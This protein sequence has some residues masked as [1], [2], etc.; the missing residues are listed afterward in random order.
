MSYVA[1]VIFATSG[2]ILCEYKLT[3][4]VLYQTLSRRLS[5][6]FQDS[7]EDWGNESTRMREVYCRAIFTIAA[8]AAY[9]GRTGLFFERQHPRMSPVQVDITWP[10]LRHIL[11]A[12][13]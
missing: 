5:C 8:T 11:Q 12:K 4:S 7:P 2:L 1:E 3:M 9:D 6:I 13:K 10:A